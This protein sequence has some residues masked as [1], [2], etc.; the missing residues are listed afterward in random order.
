MGVDKAELRL[1]GQTLLELAVAKLHRVCGEVVV[2]GERAEVPSGVRVIPDLHPGCGPLGGVEAALRDLHDVR[3]EHPA[4]WAAF[5][6]VD[7]PFVPGGLFEDLLT[8]WV[9]RG[10]TGVR[11]TMVEVDGHV[12]PLVSLVHRTVLPSVEA[13]IARGEYKV[14]PMLELAA[15]DLPQLGDIAALWKSDLFV[16]A[17]AAGR[18]GWRPSPDEWRARSLWFSNL[19]TPAEFRQAAPFEDALLTSL[20]ATP[21]RRPDR[22]GDVP[23]PPVGE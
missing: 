18:G 1:A 21:N 15:R 16:E 3:G 7:M 13:S 11:V 22:R 19:N 17:L 2:V 4:E 20:A 5:L 9:E 6:P 23:P 8:E 10:Q 12:Q 14:R